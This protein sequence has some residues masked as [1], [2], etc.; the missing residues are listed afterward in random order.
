M[1]FIFQLLVICAASW[2]IFRRFIARSP[3]DNIPGPLSPSF[4]KGNMGQLMAMNGWAFHSHIAETYGSVVKLKGV[5]NNKMLYVFDPKALH[6]IIV[7]D[8]YVYEETSV[9]IATVRLVFGMGLLSTL[10][11]H[12][13][14][15]R[16]MLN[17][18]FSGRHVRYMLLT[19]YEIAGKLR[20]AV[21]AQVASGTVEIDM[22]HWLARTS[23]E[24]IG[25][26][27]LGYSFDPLTENIENPYARAIKDLSP[28]V[29]KLAIFRQVLPPIINMSSPRFRQLM[30]N[31]LPWKT[32]H[33]VRDSV[34]MLHDL[35]CEVLEAKTSAL[36][37]GDDAVLEQIGQGKDIMSILLKANMEASEEDRLSESELLGQ[38]STFIFAALDTTSSALS[39]TLQILSENPKVQEK[40]RREIVDARRSSGGDLSHDELLALPYLDA[41]CKETL[42]LYPPI[43]TV[44]R[45]TRKD[46]VLPLSKPIRG[47][48]G[49]DISEIPIPNN[50]TIVVGIMASNRNPEIW[51]EDA[52]EWKP[53][54]WLSP[55]PDSV[56]AA[57]LPGIYSNMMTF[58]GGG[59]SCIGFKFALLELKVVLSLLLESFSF[60]P[61]VKEIVWN[62]PGQSW[63]SVKGSHTGELPIKV[64]L[65]EAA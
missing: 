54:R 55:L 64:S 62:M 43:S 18:V 40:L 49:K 19:F 24:L 58:L 9:F 42:R 56:A 41:V 60:S 15:Q 31:L 32:L 46:I 34:N 30:M 39:R 27:G 59:R 25:Q 48:D 4:W 35:S 63:P 57:R 52:L 29:F 17:P 10:G 22:L 14:K 2:A 3:L 21:A 44:A 53:E 50:T 1:I 6:H 36:R 61:S 12:H 65:A 13:R 7:R 38:V 20:D 23:L 28:A 37:S 5:F 26:S 51:G 45:T 8:Q 16:K 47:V 33:Q 11:D